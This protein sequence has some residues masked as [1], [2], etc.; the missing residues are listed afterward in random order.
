[1]NMDDTLWFS[2]LKIDQTFDHIHICSN[3]FINLTMKFK[4]FKN[5]SIK[6][7]KVLIFF[8]QFLR[9]FINLN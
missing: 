5:F 8:H 4:N 1:M 9:S 3:E 7:A 6:T 2:S